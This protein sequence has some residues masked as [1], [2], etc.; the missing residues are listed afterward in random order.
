MPII[1]TIPSWEP[2]KAT[3]AKPGEGPLG[4][5]A[6]SLVDLGPK[7]RTVLT[8]ED[9]RALTSWLTWSDG[10]P[11]LGRRELGKGEA[12]VLTLPLSLDESDLPLRPGF[13]ALLDAFVVRARAR[14]SPRR[15]EA[16]ATFQVPDGAVVEG[17][18]GRIALTH[19]PN[20]VRATVADIG[21][22]RV[23]V[24]DH[25]ETRVTSPVARELDLR[26]RPAA[27]KGHA[28]IGAGPAAKLDVSWIVAL[29]LLGL[30]LAE[31]VARLLTRTEPAA[32]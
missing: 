12:L 31:I 9:A 14:S 28:K 24:G 21:R 30:F 18:H 3:G 17:P 29:V 25:V 10:M 32:S 7:G 8:D 1:T 22:Y 20:G 5:G 13:L 16:G 4:E 11:F 27:P 15:S 23:K 19:E 26:P 6:Q 2:T